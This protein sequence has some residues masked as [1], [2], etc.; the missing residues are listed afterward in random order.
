MKA[1]NILLVIVVVGAIYYFS[2]ME[3]PK[4]VIDP[5]DV[6]K[7]DDN[8]LNKYL[9]ECCEEKKKGL[10]LGTHEKPVLMDAAKQEAIKRGLSVPK[11]VMSSLDNIDQSFNCP[12]CGQGNCRCKKL[13]INDMATNN[14]T[15]STGAMPKCKEGTAFIN[16]RCLPMPRAIKQGRMKA[17][18][19][20]KRVKSRMKQI[21]SE[22]T[23]AFPKYVNPQGEGYTIQNS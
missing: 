1:S 2:T 6:T 22:F 17:V 13:S 7:W 16:G 23:H 14:I 19:G 15:T 4:E 3:K 11:C 21:P 9:I 10:V 18:D 5:N 12:K 8:K 20:I